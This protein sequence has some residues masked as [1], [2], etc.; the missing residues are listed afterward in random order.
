MNKYPVRKRNT[1]YYLD[2]ITEEEVNNIVKTLKNKISVGW[3]GIPM[4]TVKRLKP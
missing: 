4:N 1:L 3:D 2:L